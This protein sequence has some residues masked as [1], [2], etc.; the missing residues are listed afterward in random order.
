[1]HHIE[2]TTYDENEQ[3]SNISTDKYDEFGR[4]IEWSY[5]QKMEGGCSNYSRFTQKYD[6][7]GHIIEQ[8]SYNIDGAIKEK[9][10]GSFNSNGLMIESSEYNSK[11]E[12]KK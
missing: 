11:N 9:I 12:L 6:N 5:E 7:K 1:L 3:L 4:I 8:Y 10:T 2:T